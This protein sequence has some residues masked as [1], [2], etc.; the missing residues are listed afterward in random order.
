MPARSSLGVASSA[1]HRAF[2]QPWF[3]RPGAASHDDLT[4]ESLGQRNQSHLDAALDEVAFAHP[5]RSQT[6]TLSRAAMASS[7]AMA[8]SCR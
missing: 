4:I 2:P 1:P 7:S 5:P 8:A 3:A 6:S